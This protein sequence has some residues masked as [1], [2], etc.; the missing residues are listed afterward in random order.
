MHHASC[1]VIRLHVA[2]KTYHTTTTHVT[3]RL[4]Y[5]TREAQ[6]SWIGRPLCHDILKTVKYGAGPSFDA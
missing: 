6:T 5:E 4:G 3:I 2:G 1:I